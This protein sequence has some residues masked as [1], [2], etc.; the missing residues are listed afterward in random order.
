MFNQSNLWDFTSPTLKMEAAASSKTMV[1]LQV[2]TSL[3]IITFY[4]C[5]LVQV[6]S[7]IYWPVLQ[8]THVRGHNCSQLHHVL[9]AKSSGAEEENPHTN[10]AKNWGSIT[11][12]CTRLHIRYYIPLGKW[13]TSIHSA[14]T[15]WCK[16]NKNIVQNLSM[17]SSHHL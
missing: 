17:C 2:I 12:E 5:F 13:N 3:R 15:E 14:H 8:M 4:L 6:K 16:V 11:S 9:T 10:Q 1:L 7:I